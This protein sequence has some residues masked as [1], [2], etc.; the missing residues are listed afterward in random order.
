LSYVRPVN[1]N[2]CGHPDEPYCALGMCRKCYSANHHAGT[3]PERPLT[4]V[5]QES[6]CHPG[7]PR[8]NRN[9]LCLKCYFRGRYLLRH[10]DARTKDERNRVGFATCHPDRPKRHSNG[11]CD[12][13]YIVK[14][15]YGA[16]FLAMYQ[17]QDGRCKACNVAVAEHDMRTDH[18]H[19][20]LKVR[21]LLCH[22]CNVLAGYIEHANFESVLAYLKANP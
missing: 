14:K 4:L 8:V 3:L 20:T 7:E 21:G 10:P 11:L 13:C 17:A 2:E 6:I 12:R 18:D 22:T 1:V 19:H 15:R 5:D 16:D 9:G